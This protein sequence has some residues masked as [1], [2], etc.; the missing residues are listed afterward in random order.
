MLGYAVDEIDKAALKSGETRDLE[1]EAQR[2][3]DF[4]KLSLQVN[5]AAEAL[6]DGENSVLSQARWAKNSIESAAAIDADL[7][8]LLRRMEDLYYEAEDLSGEFR[9]YR[10]A[11]SYD[12]RRL[13]EVEERLALLYRLRKK[14]DREAGTEDPEEA[15]LAYRDGAAREMEALAGAGENREK[16]RAEIASLE[17]DLAA[18]AAAI[19]GKRK[20][21]SVSLGERITGI[22]ARLGMPKARFS[23]AV[24]PKARDPAEAGE[25][26]GIVLGPWGADDVEFMI[27]ANAGEP[28]R[29]LARIASGGELSRVMLAIK[30]V[31]SGT[32]AGS[33]DASP[34]TLVFDEIDTGIGGEVALAVGEYLA[35]IGE[36]KQIFC[37]THLA[38]IAVRA[39]THLMV[40]KTGAAGGRTVTGVSVLSEEE[41]RREIARML[42]GGAGA[43]ALAHADELL[44]RYGSSRTG[45]NGGS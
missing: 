43:A 5:T 6:F 32:D 27:S 29:E 3:G 40:E 18:R 19:S 21:A 7:A 23:A 25:R 30:T 8:S 35:R 42:A 9:S 16:L 45:R 39:D 10:D 14:Y 41:R 24:Q 17:K 1:A 31:L 22:L 11:L 36:R 26:P 4:E 13:E 34:D 2:L 37:V 12:P 33:G 38:S 44:K 28:E 15:V 20:A